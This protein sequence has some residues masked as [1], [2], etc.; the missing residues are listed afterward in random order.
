MLSCSPP[1]TSPSSC[2]LLCQ[3]PLFEL[4]Q[5]RDKLLDFKPL[6]LNLDEP[7]L[8]DLRDSHLRLNHL[9]RSQEGIGGDR[10]VPRIALTRRHVIAPL[11]QLPTHLLEVCDGLRAATTPGSATAS[12][13]LV[14]RAMCPTQVRAFACWQT[15]RL[16]VPLG[17]F[18]LHFTPLNC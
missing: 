14:L 4:L 16:S 18:T 2:L 13:L 17:C 7:C 15:A 3:H 9:C 5:A 10:D 12:S 11:D 8:G 1:A 6:Q